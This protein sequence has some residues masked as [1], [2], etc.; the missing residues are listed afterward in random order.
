LTVTVKIRDR[1]FA[2]AQAVRAV[3]GKAEQNP[4]IPED[5]MEIPSPIPPEMLPSEP[6]SGQEPMGRPSAPAAPRSRKPKKAGGAKKRARPK[7]KAKAKARPA[8]KSSKVK[9]RGGKK[10]TKKAGSRAR[11]RSRSRR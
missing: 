7:A 2:L 6:M 3:Q 8:R 11:K 4:S 1:N 5:E 10:K 9:A